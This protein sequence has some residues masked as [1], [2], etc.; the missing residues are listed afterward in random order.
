[1][2]AGWC[3]ENVLLGNLRLGLFGMIDPA[4]EDLG[5]N[6]DGL[7]P[8]AIVAHL[9]R[10]IEETLG[11]IQSL[12]GWAV[13]TDPA[14]P[15]ALVQ[16]ILREIYVK[17]IGYQNEQVEAAVCAIAQMPRSMKVAWFDEMLHHQ[18]E[19][20]DHGEMAV[21]DFIG[22]GGTEAE[23]RVRPQSP[24]AFAVAAVWRNFVHKRQPF[25]YLG[26]IYLFEALTPLITGRA[27]QMLAGRGL[28][29]TGL[30]FITH[31]ATADIEHADSMKGLIAEVAFA[32]PEAKRPMLY[33]FEHFKAVYP[34][35][36]WAAAARRAQARVERRAEAAE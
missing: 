3:R 2:R 15:I 16:E 18:A 24:T 23:A 20:F 26:A 36:C 28:A 12:D 27:M 31:H 29:P 35:P 22:Y 1:M 30:E 32:Y 5:V 13:L 34:L 21:R 14:T 8:D 6:P 25:M 17:I 33:G 11:E 4:I 19:E 7:S 10:R 9:D